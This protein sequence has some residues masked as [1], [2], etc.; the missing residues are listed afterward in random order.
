MRL[1][2][3]RSRVLK[4]RRMPRNAVDTEVRSALRLSGDE[5]NAQR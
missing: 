4:I 2:V 3:P 1:A 5:F